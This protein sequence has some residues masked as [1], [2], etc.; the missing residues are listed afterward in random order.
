ETT[1]NQAVHRIARLKHAKG[2][3]SNELNLHQIA[4]KNFMKD[5][6]EVEILDTS[7]PDYPFVRHKKTGQE[8]YIMINELDL[9]SSDHDNVPLNSPPDR[10]SSEASQIGASSTNASQPT[11]RTLPTPPIPQGI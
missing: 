11:S 3:V 7:S 8:F 6:E 9:I 1:S 2:F 4:F 5:G 10:R